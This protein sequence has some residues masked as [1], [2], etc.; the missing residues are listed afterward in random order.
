MQIAREDT[1]RRCPSTIGARTRER[2]GREV[3]ESSRSAGSA[4]GPEL[5]YAAKRTYPEEKK[6]VDRSSAS[7][8]SWKSEISP[9]EKRTR[10]CFASRSEREEKRE[11]EREEES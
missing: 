11:R 3:N 4:V 2:G 1:A 10:R 8:A 5:V 6:K 9:A 7:P